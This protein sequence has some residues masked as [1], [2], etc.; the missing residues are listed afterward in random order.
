MKILH[1]MSLCLLLGL[2]L[3]PKDVSALKV[4]THVWIADEIIKDLEDGKLTIYVNGKAIYVTINANL[5]NYILNHKK[6]FRAGTLGPDAFP[7]IAV[8]QVS[9]HPGAKERNATG[10]TW[11]TDR[12][13]KYIFDNAQHPP[14][15][16][17]AYGNLVHAA[18]DIIAHSYVNMYAGEIFDVVEHVSI[19]TEPDRRHFLLESYIG[20]L[21][22]NLDNGLNYKSSVAF[23]DTKRYIDEQYQLSYRQCLAEEK[24]E[25]ADFDCDAW[26]SRDVYGDKR[27][28]L[29]RTF[30]YDPSDIVS[31][32]NTYGSNSA[33]KYPTQIAQY[34]DA[35]NESVLGGTHLAAIYQLR[36][37]IEQLIQSNALL[38][39]D[40]EITKNVVYYWTNIRLSDGQA[41]IL[42]DLHQDVKTLEYKS[43]EELQQ[44]KNKLEDILQNSTLKIHN[45]TEQAALMVDRHNRALIQ[46]QS[47]IF[48]IE[49]KILELDNKISRYSCPPFD[50]I[51]SALNKLKR[52]LRTAKSDLTR[53]ITNYAS[54]RNLLSN[55][56]KQL[57]ETVQG[58]ELFRRSLDDAAIDLAQVFMK[59]VNPI[60]AIL[61]NWAEGIDAAM[62]SYR[63]VGMEM[64]QA[65]MVNENVLAPLENWAF[66][67]CNVAKLIGIGNELGNSVCR[68]N[69]NGQALIDEVNQLTPFVNGILLG[70]IQT[71]INN[72]LVNK[73]KEKLKGALVDAALSKV[74]PEL[75]NFIEA[76]KESVSASRLNNEFS[77]GG[78]Q[79]YLNI[80]DMSARVDAEMRTTSNYSTCKG[81]AKCF[82][83]MKSPLIFNAIQLSKLAMLGKSELTS[84]ASQTN[85]LVDLLDSNG[86][87]GSNI[88]RFNGSILF[89]GVKS[90]DGNH[91]WFGEL[92][93]PLPRDKTYPQNYSWEVNHYGY[94]SGSLLG[95]RESEKQNIMH[96]VFI[97]PLN[98]GLFTP[99][100]LG[101]ETQPA[102]L[103]DIY[104]QSFDEC[105]G[106]AF[107]L[108]RN[109]HFCNSVE[110]TFEGGNDNGGGGGT[111]PPWIED[112]GPGTGVICK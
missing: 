92:S 65:A 72:L 90:I 31:L 12:W 48:N 80:A 15:K 74:D 52:K 109:D 82:D 77:N 62:L 25:R 57:H 100:A 111:R 50:P 46:A 88:S 2:Y 36:Y 43:V 23:P 63:T 13:L 32:V 9:I 99:K 97:G 83:K 96:S 35:A 89:N 40:I 61:I 51:C 68:L 66:T 38:E 91:Q 104:R 69:R 67:Q 7:D 78:N 28:F 14:E 47:K 37:R 94:D 10:K 84:L 70:S 112:C 71:D 30:I 107:Q 54:S 27:D 29:S 87:G 59:D 18:S 55:A 49:D 76:V 56:I 106:H 1:T 42:N 75:I 53:E 8:G 93:P 58:V 79:G 86:Y 98:E 21:T 102:I 33:I 108:S 17:F 95:Q 103:T 105:K 39:M 4:N 22:P 34:L 6:E 26:A 45:A 11:N 60:R 19:D 41:S 110:D 73:V 81:K 3:F 20:N 16:A 24:A 64:M 44:I 85:N 101:F 5:R